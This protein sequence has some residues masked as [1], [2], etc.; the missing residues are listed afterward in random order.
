MIFHLI[1]TNLNSNS[2]LDSIHDIHDNVSNN[3]YIIQYTYDQEL[4]YAIIYRGEHA[5]GRAS[6]KSNKATKLT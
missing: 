2:L 5:Y 1:T 3:K 6:H 4:Q